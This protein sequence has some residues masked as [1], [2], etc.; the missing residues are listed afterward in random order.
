MGTE[1]AEAFWAD[2]KHPFPDA[3]TLWRV[4]APASRAAD[5]ADAGMGPWMMDWGG[6]RI[7]LACEDDEAVRAA[8]E[9]VGGHAMMVR[10][11]E[12]QKRRV[13]ALHPQ[14]APVM[15]LEQRLRRAFDPAGVF[16]TG[17]FLDETHAD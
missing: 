1:E 14:P 13:P 16:E 5:I 2:L 8:A 4:S 7:W 15:A 6:A 12:A 11:A 3:P 10:A 17:R 9:S